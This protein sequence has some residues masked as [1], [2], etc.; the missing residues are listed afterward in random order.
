MNEILLLVLLQYCYG[1][2]ICLVPDFIG[3]LV[4]RAGPTVAASMMVAASMIMTVYLS[5]CLLIDRLELTL[6]LEY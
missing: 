1:L 5:V 4:L 3:N 6:A 2:E